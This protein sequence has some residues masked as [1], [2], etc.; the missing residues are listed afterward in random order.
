MVL[1]RACRTS[2]NTGQKESNTIMKLLSRAFLLTISFFLTVS[3]AKAQE[4][5][6]AVS[7]TVTT[8]HPKIQMTDI[9][10]DDGSPDSFQWTKS[11]V[12]INFDKSVSA[13]TVAADKYTT[14]QAPVIAYYYGVGQ[15]RTLVAVHELGTGPFVKSIGRVVKLDRRAHLLT[16]QNSKGG[17]EIFAIDA[18]TVAD[19]E[20]GVVTNFKFDYNKGVQV[21]VIAAQ[22]NG[23]N[24]ALL[25]IPI[26]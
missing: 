8:I 24:T 10:T 19:T 11:G 14:L 16:I 25:I 2:C 6:H 15:V 3:T 9:Q 5:V 21:R 17:E 20:T 23:S 18:K 1:D 13:D 7:G 26:F 12:A 4:M 22:A